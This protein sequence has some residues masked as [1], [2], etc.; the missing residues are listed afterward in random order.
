MKPFPDNLSPEDRRAY[1]RWTVGM[2]LSY[3]VAVVV[4]IGIIFMNRPA[5]DLRASNETQFARSNGPTASM[6][7]SPA[8]RPDTR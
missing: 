5:S 3:L 6:E 8:A 2:F 7:V 4:T 1:R